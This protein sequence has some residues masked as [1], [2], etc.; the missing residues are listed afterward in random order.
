[1]LFDRVIDCYY[2]LVPPSAGELEAWAATRDDA[3]YLGRGHFLGIPKTAAKTSK[4]GRS[5]WCVPM[6]SAG[7]LASPE[8]VSQLL[9][10]GRYRVACREGYVVEP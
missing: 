2:V 7:A 6:D 3:E 8:A 1:V 5:Y 10:F 9:S 4:Q